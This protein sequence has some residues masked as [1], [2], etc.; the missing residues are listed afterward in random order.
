MQI[1]SLFHPISISAFGGA[2]IMP[3]KKTPI[4][5]TGRELI[6]RF[7]PN[8]RY[9][10]PAHSPGNGGH[11]VRTYPCLSVRQFKGGNPS[12]SV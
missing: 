4:P 1:P 6:S 9:T 10:R 2:P 8:W 3:N 11:P 5:V 7:H 12:S